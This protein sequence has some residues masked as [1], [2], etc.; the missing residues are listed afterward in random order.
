MIFHSFPSR[1]G[2]LRGRFSAGL[3]REGVNVRF[4]CGGVGAAGIAKDCVNNI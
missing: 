1:P 4:V 3:G 2:R